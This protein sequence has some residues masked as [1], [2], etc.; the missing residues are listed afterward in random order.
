[1]DVSLP[2]NTLNLEFIPLNVMGYLQTKVPDNIFCDLK[3]YVASLEQ[4][5]ISIKSINDAKENSK[6]NNNFEE[7][8]NPYLQRPSVLRSDF[9]GGIEQ[10]YRLPTNPNLNNF[11]LSLCDHYW[12]FVYLKSRRCKI[13]NAWINF[14]KKREAH[15]IHIHSSVLSFVIWLKIP[16]NLENEQK[17]VKAINSNGMGLQQSVPAFTF[18][19]HG[20]SRDTRNIATIKEH[21]IPVSNKHEG[22][23]I[24]FDSSLSHTVLPF[25][26]SDEYRISIAGNIVY[27][28]S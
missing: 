15:H 2:K 9:A 18:V 12:D 3:S 27:D 14:Q 26:T 28:N 22:T 23:I 10:V 8:Y 13:D 17:A 20:A 11:I 21:S 1:M 6:I 16:Y 25:Y 5:S 4:N 7:Q 19:Y 24:L